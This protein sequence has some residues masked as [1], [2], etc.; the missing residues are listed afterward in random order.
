M[1]FLERRPI[2][3]TLL[4]S[5]AVIFSVYAVQAWMTDRFGNTDAKSPITAPPT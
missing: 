2:L 5:S 3:A 1:T 4:I